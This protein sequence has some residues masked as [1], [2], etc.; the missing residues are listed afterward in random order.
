MQIKEQYF[1]VNGCGPIMNI[2]IM[3]D[4]HFGSPAFLEHEYERLAKI[5]ENDRHAHLIFLGDLIDSN[6]PSTRLL[7]RVAYSSR[8]EEQKQQDDRDSYWIDN[9]IIPKLKRII[10]HKNC[11]GMLDGDHYL[12]MENGISTTQAVCCKMGLPY[13][14]DGQVILK[15]HFQFRNRSKQTKI[16]AIHCQHGIGGAGRPSAGVNKLEETANIWEGVDI[17]ARGHSHKGF[18]LPISKYIIPQLKSE[19]QQHDIWLVNTPSF[20]T[21]LILGET[22]YAE[23][24]NYPATAHKFPVIHVTGRKQRKDNSDYTLCVT[25][26]LI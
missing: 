24:R 19:I 9:K 17:F 26:E 22:D 10:K 2:Y 18:I 15:L 8:K 23:S 1:L 3:P 16:L 7:K 13:L 5:I 4:C 12:E 21:G 14:G 25:G 20:R 6:R 11:L